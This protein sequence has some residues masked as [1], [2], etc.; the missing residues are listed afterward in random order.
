MTTNAPPAEPPTLRVEGGLRAALAPERLRALGADALLPFL[1]G[2][3]W[4]GAKG[5]E[6]RDA[7]VGAVVQLPWDNKRFV[8]TGLDVDFGG[9]AERYQLPLGVRWQGLGASAADEPRAVL[10]R[11]ES[12]EERGVLFDATEDATFRAELVRAFARGET[13]EATDPLTGGLLRWVIEP[14]GDGLAG[15]AATRL[16]AAEQSNTSIIVGDRAILKLFRRLEPGENPD[17]EI[18]RFLATHTTF[19]GTPAL[20]GDVRFEDERGSSG[21]GMLQRFVPGS[22]DAWHYAL[23]RARPYVA[24]PR[25]AE[26]RN[27]FAADAERLGRVTRALHDALASAGPDEP[28]FAPEPVRAEDVARWAE[29]ARRSVRE[30]LALLERRLGAGAVG[31]ERAAEARV[32]LGRGEHYLG[33]VDELAHGVGADAG[34]KIRHHGDYHLG[35]VLRAPDG[36]FFI[37]DFEGEPAR[38]LA[39][40]R[41]KSSALRDVA[42]MLRS[43]AYAAATTAAGARNSLDMTTVEVR[44]GRWEREAREAFLRGY[45]RAE[46]AGEG[47]GEGGDES[48]DFLPRTP[49]HLR[50]LTALFETEKVF[51]ELAY[52]LNNRP[53]WVWIPLRGISKLL[54]A[55]AIARTGV[56]ARGGARER[57]RGTSSESASSV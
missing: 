3:R 23:E 45:A 26:P 32:L 49:E 16:G 6:P 54:V 31:G 15:D 52:E 35:Q 51:Y 38:P 43:F 22:G 34:Q 8:L 5:R 29:S 18:A 36:E 55:P 27:D 56:G 7:R 24:A 28:E 1:A 37:I 53:D 42:G 25:G 4:F 33:Y 17:V 21:A 12:G 48:A 30:G 13:F 40:R 50:Q 57:G 9:R 19:T 47:S 44:S 10:A 41:A 39:E 11:V 14:V 2:R 46:R 20:L